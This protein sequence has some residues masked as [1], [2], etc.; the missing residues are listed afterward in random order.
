MSPKQL[1]CLIQVAIKNFMFSFV[2]EGPL[3]S[4]GV[5]NNPRAVENRATPPVQD[6]TVEYSAVQYSRVQCSTV[7]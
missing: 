3:R 2:P 6:S 7:Q 4:W 1:Q 5:E